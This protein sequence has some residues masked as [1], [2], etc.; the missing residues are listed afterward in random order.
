MG[1]ENSR[2]G[3]R[4]ENGGAV[5]QHFQRGIGERVEEKMNEKRGK[6]REGERG[7]GKEEGR[8]ST[9]LG[10]GGSF[11]PFYIPL[12]LP[13][14]ALAADQTADA[15]EKTSFRKRKPARASSLRFA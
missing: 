13:H 14:L 7:G 10:Q 9:S 11:I 12:P 2:R 5:K 15:P 6:E 4:E 3:E 1:R 8:G